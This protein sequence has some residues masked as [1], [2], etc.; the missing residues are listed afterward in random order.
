MTTL[1][2]SHRKICQKRIDSM[3]R[4]WPDETDEEIRE[5]IQSDAEDELA[6][7]Q[8]KLDE[9]F[10]GPVHMIAIDL[11]RDTPYTI[12]SFNHTGRSLMPITTG[13][14]CRYYWNGGGLRLHT[15]NHDFVIR[16]IDSIDVAS[17][18]RLKDAIENKDLYPNEK[19]AIIDTLTTAIPEVSIT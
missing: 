15:E 17:I 13:Q 7:V 1:W 12:I 6:Y 10:P 18:M 11:T 3:K 2:N 9:L 4:F 8:N 14:Q 5:R 19:M 16:T